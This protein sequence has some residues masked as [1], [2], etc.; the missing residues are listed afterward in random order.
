MNQLYSLLQQNTCVY[1]Y[2]HRRIQENP[3]AQYLHKLYE[4]ASENETE[5]T[6]PQTTVFLMC[7]HLPNQP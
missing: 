7:F 5:I 2:T 3:I 4:L 6:Y 1:I